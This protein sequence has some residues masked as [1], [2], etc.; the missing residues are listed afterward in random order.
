MAS[1]Q[2]VGHWDLEAD[3]VVL[4]C[5]LAG[6]MAA[7]EAREVDP[8][9]SILI[10]EKMPP[11]KAGGNSRVSGQSLSFPTD[12]VAYRRYQEALNRPHPIPAHLMDAW[13]A[14]RTGQKAW[15]ERKAAEVGFEL[16]PWGR[17]GAE[18][19]SMPGAECIDDLYTLRPAS[20]GNGAGA[21][22][23]MTYPSGVYLCFKAHL[24]RTAGIAVHHS[25]R[26]RDLVHDPDTREV[27]GVIATRDHA[28]IAVKAKRGVIVATGGFEANRETLATFTGYTSAVR[29]YGSPANT[30]DGLEMLQR[31]GAKLWHMRNHTETGGIHPGIK[32]PGHSLLLRN[33]RPRATSWI[34]VA[35]NGHR[36]YP[37]GGKYHDTHFKYQLHGVWEDIPTARVAPVYMI[38]DETTRLTDTLAGSNLTWG[39][40]VEGYHWSR[41]NS[42]EIEKGW[43]HRDESIA[44]LASK[45]GL[46]A[47]QLVDEVEKFNGYARAG[48]D[49][50][51]GRA[52]RY[53]SPLE[54]P[55]FH[56]IDIAP[57]L[58]CTTGG[59][60]RDEH[61]RVLDHDERP[62]PRLHEAG[63]LGSFHSNLYQNGSFLTEAM[64]SGRW[65]GRAAVSHAPW[66]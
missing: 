27:F 63:E 39:A 9:A 30:G 26:A 29:P 47:A 55:P 25:T 43:I 44:G 51:F 19:A 24:D 57:G 4:G 22:V 61:G 14:G 10:L 12:M 42:V 18:F 58:V 5:G 37:E 66:N 53:M 17:F 48:L 64:F 3:V 11:A 54:R 41:D 36:F 28:S 20:A 8:T 7:L 13:V 62:I 35:A 45:I 1:L 23:E 21:R 6:M 38:F 46:D 52:P 16:V 34:D 32:V 2:S 31:V 49:A 65:A 33:S 50:E 56:A 15:V 40:V 59:A 60:M